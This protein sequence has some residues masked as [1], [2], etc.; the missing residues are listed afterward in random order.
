MAPQNEKQNVLELKSI[1]TKFGSKVVHKDVSFSVERGTIVSLIGSSGSGKSTILRE[2][3]G[4]LRPA[5]GSIR[6]LDQDVLEGG[7]EVQ[8]ELRRRYG[9]LFQNG[10][11]FSALSVGEN[12]AV[13]LKEQT[14]LPEHLIRELVALQLGLVGLSPDVALKMPSELSGGMRKRAALARALVLCPEVVFLDEPTSGLDPISARAFDT[15]VRTLCDSIGLTIFLVTHDLDTILSI[16]DK[17]I[18]LDEGRVIGQGPVEEVRRI[19]HAWIREYFS[20]RH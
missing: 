7:V 19:D 11:L 10:A 17:L 1:Q 5:G 3:V 2:V 12:I 15:L 13:P 9:V 18:V 8:N 6:L 16:T 14:D 4:L 20:T